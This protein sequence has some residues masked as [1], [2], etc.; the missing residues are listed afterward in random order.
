MQEG[1]DT[2]GHPL[3]SGLD[4]QSCGGGSWGERYRLGGEKKP[5]LDVRQSGGIVD[6]IRFVNAGKIRHG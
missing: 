3:S 6:G 1:Q 2:V 5:S 4:L